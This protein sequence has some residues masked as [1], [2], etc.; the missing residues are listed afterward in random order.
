MDPGAVSAL[1][2]GMGTSKRIDDVDFLLQVDVE[3]GRRFRQSL[4]S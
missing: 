1:P 4:P 3:Q 2:P